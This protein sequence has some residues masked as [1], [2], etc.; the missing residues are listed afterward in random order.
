VDTLQ[1]LLLRVISVGQRDGS[2]VQS[3]Y[4]SCRRRALHPSGSSGLTITPAPGAQAPSF[5]L[6]GYQS[7]IQCS[8]IQAGETFIHIKSF[9]KKRGSSQWIMLSLMA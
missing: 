1:I 7:H 9:L 3:T 6:L 8:Y 4:C 5:V 2:M